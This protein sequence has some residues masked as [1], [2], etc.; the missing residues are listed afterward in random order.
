MFILPLRIGASLII[1][2][3]RMLRTR[4]PRIYRHRLL[5][6]VPSEGRRR[7]RRRLASSNDRCCLG[8]AQQAR[9]GSLFWIRLSRVASL[10]WSDILDPR[11]SLRLGIRE[12][13]DGRGDPRDCSGSDRYRRRSGGRTVEFLPEGRDVF[14]YLFF[15]HLCRLRRRCLRGRCS[16]TRKHSPVVRSS[17]IPRPDRYWRC[18]FRNRAV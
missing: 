4:R 3:A 15:V 18:R 5:G 2:R 17:T 16:I 10:L 6:L 13:T 8:N 7:R 1:I 14:H 11:I 12:K 9:S